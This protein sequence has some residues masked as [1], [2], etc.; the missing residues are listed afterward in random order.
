MTCTKPQ[1]Q[2][3]SRVPVYRRGDRITLRRA[4]AAC[5]DRDCLC[6]RT[7]TVRALC[8]VLEESSGRVVWRV[9][10]EDGRAVEVG[11]IAKVT[12]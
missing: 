8:A 6:G 5:P 3:C 11:R 12:Q 7:V 9:V 1:L 10:L 4:H 2:Q